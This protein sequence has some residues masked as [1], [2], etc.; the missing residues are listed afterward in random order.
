MIYDLRVEPI[1]CGS[2]VQILSRF[3][4]VWIDYLEVF[5]CTFGRKFSR[6]GFER[7]ASIGGRLDYLEQSS[8]GPQI[9]R[10][11]KLDRLLRAYP[12]IVIR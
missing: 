10:V 8:G 9:G 2:L 3:P 4:G 6:F 7:R 12:K 5:V 1:I 11:V